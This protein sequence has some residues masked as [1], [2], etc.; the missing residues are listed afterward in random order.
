LSPKLEWRFTVNSRFPLLLV[1]AACTLLV[2]GCTGPADAPVARLDVTA[3]S[4]AMGGLGP[5][6]LGSGAAEIET[7]EITSLVPVGPNV[8]QE[9][10]ITGSLTGALDG[11]FVEHAR[12][13]VHHTGLVTYQATFVFTGTVAGCTGEGSFTA[14]LSGRGQGGPAPVT[15]ANFRIIDQASNTLRIAG[16]G[17]MNQNGFD[18][19]YEVRYVCA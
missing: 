3:P 19:T 13:M 5:P 14:S 2:I 10:T 7:L 6:L 8:R 11:T 16:T 17:T 9:R 12:G 1:G 18:A 4:F 15:E